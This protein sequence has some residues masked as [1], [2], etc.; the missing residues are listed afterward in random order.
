[1]KLAGTGLIGGLVVSIC[2]VF[3]YTPTSDDVTIIT[4]VLATFASGALVL[5]NLW[6]SKRVVSA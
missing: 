4:G 2:G 1:M 5:Y 6:K 3:G